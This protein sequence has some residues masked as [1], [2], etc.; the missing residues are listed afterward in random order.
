MSTKICPK[1][2]S[3]VY[4]NLYFSRFLCMNPDCGYVEVI[5]NEQWIEPLEKSATSDEI[6]SR[7]NEIINVLNKIT[8]PRV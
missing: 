7:L 3:V 6:I 1:C 2:G 5:K 8:N 4:K